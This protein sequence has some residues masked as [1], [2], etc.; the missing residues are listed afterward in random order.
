MWSV[1]YFPMLRFSVD[2]QAPSEPLRS[3]AEYTL[4]T[5]VHLHQS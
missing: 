4:D 3:G 1:P 5:V 2:V